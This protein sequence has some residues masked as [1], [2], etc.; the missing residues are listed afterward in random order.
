MSYKTGGYKTKYIEECGPYVYNE[1]IIY[2]AV[3]SCSNVCM[4]K[5]FDNK[6]REVSI[7]I[8]AE[9]DTDD[10]GNHSLIDCLYYL[11]CH[12]DKHYEWKEHNII[13]EEMTYEEVDKIFGH[14]NNS[15]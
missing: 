12:K 14:H 6:G 4:Y 5:M 15:N 2:C 9:E 3:E 13:I 10:F 7:S 1:Y 11:K 8:S